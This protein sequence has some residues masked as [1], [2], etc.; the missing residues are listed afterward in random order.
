[1]RLEKITELCTPVKNFWLRHWF[2]SVI[3]SFKI[4]GVVQGQ[5]FFKRSLNISR[6]SHVVGRRLCQF[7]DGS[8]TE[9]VNDFSRTRYSV[10]ISP[11]LYARHYLRTARSTS[12]ERAFIH[13][14][15]GDKVAS[16]P[17]VCPVPTISTYCN[18]GHE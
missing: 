16:R 10:R 9:I 17:S 8:L 13:F 15:Q 2:I 4:A 7:A 12:S 6:K 11:K 3:N 5:G 18:A 14:Y 1:L